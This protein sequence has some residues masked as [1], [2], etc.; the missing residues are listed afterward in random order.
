MAC[1]CVQSLR[2]RLLR[3]QPRTS[4]RSPPPS[5]SPP[6][7]PPSLSQP[8]HSP[9]PRRRAAQLGGRRAGSSG[10]AAR[11]R[12]CRQLGRRAAVFY[13]QVEG[14]VAV[15]PRPHRRRAHRRIV[16]W[17]SW[18]SAVHLAAER[19]RD[20]RRPA[21]SA[22]CRRSAT[23]AAADSRR[24]FRQRAPE[25]GARAA[26]RPPNPSMLCAGVSVDLLRRVARAPSPLLCAL[27]RVA[28]PRAHV[29]AALCSGG[30]TSAGAWPNAVRVRRRRHDPR[31]CEP[32]R[33][34][35]ASRALLST[36]LCAVPR[37]PRY[38]LTCVFPCAQ[39]PIVGAAVTRVQWR[40]H[41]P[42]LPTA[43]SACTTTCAITQCACLVAR[44]AQRRT[45][46]ALRSVAP[47]AGGGCEGCW[48]GHRAAQWPHW[49]PDPAD[50]LIFS[51]PDCRV[52]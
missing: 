5:R 1:A 10:G 16:R 46:H 42:A 28:A 48:G 17:R 37:W 13:A 7:P 35:V 9:P 45:R 31:C 18:R 21:R 49:R 25:C 43:A 52:G 12:A 47:E 50:R 4:P 19:R 26:P 2:A 14:A 3:P 8:S 36:A 20:R 29:S 23:H 32:A 44:Q 15:R 41:A 33:G 22:G 38:A 6:S 34:C 51:V 40:N 27:R 24:S 11:R 30:V 39:A